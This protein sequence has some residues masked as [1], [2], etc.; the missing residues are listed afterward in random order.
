MCMYSIATHVCVCLPCC[1]MSVSA[2][3]V[4]IHMTSAGLIPA[5]SVVIVSSLLA[6]LLPMWFLANMRMLYVEEGC[7][8][9]MVAWLSWGDTSLVLWAVSQEPAGAEVKVYVGL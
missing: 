1:C 2:F 5:S 9:M 8:S 3:C 4:C 6:S 7:R